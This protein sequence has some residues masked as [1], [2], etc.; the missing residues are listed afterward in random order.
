MKLKENF[1]VD[2]R[3]EKVAVI[4]SIKEY[5]RMLS[6]IEEAEDIKAYRKV[7]AIKTGVIAFE[8][9]VVEIEQKR[10]KKR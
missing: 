8:K 10:K 7:K 1:V 9:A 6:E 2:D 3:G 5:E 4:L